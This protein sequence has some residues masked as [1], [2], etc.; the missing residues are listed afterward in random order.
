MSGEYFYTLDSRGEAA[1][2]NGFEK[3]GVA[4]YVYLAAQQGT[5]PLFRVNTGTEHFYTISDAER[6]LA[7]RDGATDEGIV[8]HVYAEPI[9]GTKPLYRLVNPRYHF[10]TVSEEERINALA[11]GYT[12]EGIACYVYDQE[13]ASSGTA[14]LFRWQKTDFMPGVKFDPEFDVDARLRIM[15]GHSEAYFKMKTCSSLSQEEKTKLTELYT[16]RMGVATFVYISH[17]IETNSESNASADIGTQI[18]SPGIRRGRIRINMPVLFPQ[19]DNE[20]AQTLLHEM[21][22]VAN[23]NHPQRRNPPA[24][25]DC[26][27]TPNPASYDCPHDN[28]PY[29]SSAP[30]RAELCIVG[31]QSLA[32]TNQDINTTVNVSATSP[33]I[34]AIYYQGKHNVKHQAIVERVIYGVSG[35]VQSETL[36][37]KYPED[38]SETYEWG[39]HEKASLH[40]AY[41][42]LNDA[43]S[44]RSVAEKLHVSFA[45]EIV[46]SLPH[47]ENHKKLHLGDIEWTLSIAEVR[48]WIAIHKGLAT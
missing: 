34:A 5:T 12:G 16:G 36:L 25:V 47:L 46:A 10:F 35:G 31:Q 28:G 41:T 20:I 48:H 3:N 4:C 42:I 23:F 7:I 11:N 33:P 2:L 1:S 27:T 29:Y 26:T 37:S 43:C 14:A 6:D 38:G 13:N 9:P 44:D 8:C 19:G 22:H 21:M 24:G 18:L 32:L 30:L 39:S 45:Q 40:L 15:R 17:G